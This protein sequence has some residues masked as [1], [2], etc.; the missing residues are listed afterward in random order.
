MPCRTAQNDPD[1]E[2][3]LVLLWAAEALLERFVDRDG[4]DHSGW[5]TTVDHIRYAIGS[6]ASLLQSEQLPLGPT[7]VRLSRVL[8]ARFN[9]GDQ[10]SYV[11]NVPSIVHTP[12]P[13]R[14]H[15]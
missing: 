2:Q 3:A 9:I 8:A 11:A 5:T 10:Q 6:Q 13:R 14:K 15:A 12:D 1:A 7:A 4:R